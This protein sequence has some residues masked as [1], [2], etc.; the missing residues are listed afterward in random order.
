MER[1]FLIKAGGVDSTMEIIFPS[2]LGSFNYKVTRTDKKGLYCQ[3]S[4]TRDP[5]VAYS[6]NNTSSLMNVTILNGAVGGKMLLPPSRNISGVRRGVSITVFMSTVANLPNNYDVTPKDIP[7]VVYFV[8]EIELRKGAVYIAEI[9]TIVSADP[10]TSE[11][12]CPDVHESYGRF[13]DLV[14]ECV[15]RTLKE[16][17]F[18]VVLEIP[19]G[20]VTTAKCCMYINDVICDVPAVSFPGSTITKPVLRFTSRCSQRHGEVIVK[21]M[22]IDFSKLHDNPR[23]VDDSGYTYYIGFD[24]ELVALAK[25]S[26]DTE[27]RRVTMETTNYKKINKTLKDEN[28]RLKAEL[29]DMEGRYNRQYKEEEKRRE[30][31]NKEKEFADKERAR[32]FDLLVSSV[33]F[34]ITLIPLAVILFKTFSKPSPA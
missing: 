17:P 28:D 33:K 30:Q 7:C 34:L 23:L 11:L 6:F 14:K 16:Q 18:T 13:K 4:P 31:Y 8:D 3:V 27:A 26:D 15:N 2:C 5:V 20:T 12:V 10:F 29:N 1:N 24:A 19:R 22:E 21:N 25:N 32:I 9:N